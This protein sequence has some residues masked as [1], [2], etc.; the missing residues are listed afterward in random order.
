MAN[1]GRNEAS[2]AR[3]PSPSNATDSIANDAPEPDDNGN[4]CTYACKVG[5]HNAI[6]GGHKHNEGDDIEL[7]HDEIKTLRAAGVAIHCDEVV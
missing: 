5:T 1:R 2:G 3:M 4:A 6:I 7:T